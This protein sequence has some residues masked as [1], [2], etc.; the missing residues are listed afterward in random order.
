M[1]VLE[2]PGAGRGLEQG[3]G[4]TAN[5]VALEVFDEDIIVIRRE[6]DPRQ[7]VIVYDGSIDVL[8]QHGDAPLDCQ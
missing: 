3:D 6:G 7:V 8:V 5:R 2:Q 4:F 1:V